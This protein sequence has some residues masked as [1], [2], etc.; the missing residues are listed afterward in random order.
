MAPVDCISMRRLSILRYSYFAE[1]RYRCIYCIH[2]HRTQVISTMQTRLHSSFAAIRR[3]RQVPISAR[4]NRHS[5]RHSSSFN[6]TH[7]ST[8]TA[9]PALTHVN[10]SGQAHMVDVG[11]KGATTRVAIAL[12]IV[13]LSDPE[14]FRLVQENGVKK[15]DVLGVAR[16]AGI[17]AAKR[18]SDLIPLCHPLAI[19]KLAVDTALIPPQTEHT[20]FPP[21]TWLGGGDGFPH[22]AIALQAQVQCVGPTGVEME[23]LTA[24]SVAALT[25]YDMCKAVDRA[26]TFDTRLVF[27]HGGKTGLWWEETWAK[28]LVSRKFFESRGWLD[29]VSK[30]REPQ[31]QTKDGL[32]K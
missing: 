24:A 2:V 9:D 26:A 19:T 8:V 12:S 31:D 13:R 23:A 25:V 27:K 18:T 30:L 20:R 32:F 1:V 15:G 5:S 29:P 10:P 11:A 4:S 16:T 28:S 14:T 6:K 22:G 21:T 3:P 7:P 17:M